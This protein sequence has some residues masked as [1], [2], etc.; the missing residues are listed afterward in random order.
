MHKTCI[1]FMYVL[2]LTMN[3]NSNVYGHGGML[4]NVDEGNSSTIIKHHSFVPMLHSS[5]CYY[6]THIIISNTKPST[7]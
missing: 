2:Q 7:H 4:T 3:V 1:S 5:T 6:L